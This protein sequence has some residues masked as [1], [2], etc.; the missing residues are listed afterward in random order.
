MD[1]TG[2]TA[3]VDVGGTKVAVG[4]LDG[5]TLSDSRL[6]P[7]AVDDPQAL[8]DQIAR[9]VR[10]LGPV[11][12]VGVGVPSVIRIADGRVMSTTNIAAFRDV[13]LR[14]ALGERLGLPV[15]VDNDGN[16]AALSE[17]WGDD[18]ELLH[19]SLVGVTVGTGI[20]SGIVLDGRPLHGARTSAVELG[21]LTIAADPSTGAPAAGSAPLPTSLETWASGRAL[22]RLAR[23]RGYEDGMAVTDA[24]EAGEPS[25]IEALAILG[26]RVGIGIAAAI[27]LIEPEVVVVGGGVSRAG[28]LLVGPARAAARRLLLPGLGSETEIRVAQHGPQAGVRGAALLARI[29]ETRTR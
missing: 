24:A 20:G 14:D 21:H 11:D 2:R 17:A 23:E 18:L 27:T 12:G 28:E 16:L 10:A 8:L 5:T 1:R 19:R 26:E 6:E 7:T 4:L 3:G 13:A 9:M 22:D 15:H 29:E 25:A